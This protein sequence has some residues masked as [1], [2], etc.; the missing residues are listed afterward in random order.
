MRKWKIFGLY[1]LGGIT[2]GIIISFVARLTIV[3]CLSDNQLV[4]LIPHGVA[5]V[6]LYLLLRK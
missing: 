4:R 3:C 6:S 2:I 1:L 5:A